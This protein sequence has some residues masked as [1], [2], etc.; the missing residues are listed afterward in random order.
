[1]TIRAASGLKAP[2]YVREHMSWQDMHSVHFS[3]A[4]ARLFLFID[5]PFMDAFHGLAWDEQMNPDAHKR[6]LRKRIP[7]LIFEMEAAFILV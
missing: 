1:M 5:T 7:S 2:V 4:M 6:G 3:M